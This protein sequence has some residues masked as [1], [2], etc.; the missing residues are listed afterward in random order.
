MNAAGVKWLQVTDHTC[1]NVQ[2]SIICIGTDFKIV[3]T[4][5]LLE[6]SVTEE[7]TGLYGLCFQSKSQVQES[8]VC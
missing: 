3:S 2:Q 5:K 1:T 7:N 4:Q 6:V 8:S